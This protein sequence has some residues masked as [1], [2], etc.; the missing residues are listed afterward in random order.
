MPA[1]EELEQR[2]EAEFTAARNQIRAFQTQAERSYEAARERFR[3][4]LRVARRIRKL[5]QPRIAVLARR[6]PLE[7]KPSLYHNRQQYRGAVA[8]H[9]PSD[10]ARITLRFS[11]NHDSD[12][13]N[14]F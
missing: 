7:V 6:F 8:I 11:A 2:L 14:L 5:L 12:S 9:V 3:A 1:I 13:R 4:V 10:L